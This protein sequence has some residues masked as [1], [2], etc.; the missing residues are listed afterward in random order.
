MGHMVQVMGV[1]QQH[2]RRDPSELSRRISLV[3][4][5][6]TVTEL[7]ASGHGMRTSLPQYTITTHDGDQQAVVLYSKRSALLQR[8]YFHCDFCAHFPGHN[9][10]NAKNGAIATDKLYVLL[11]SSVLVDDLGAR[12]RLTGVSGAPE[13]ISGSGRVRANRDCRI[14]NIHRSRRF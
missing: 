9:Q 7:P 14:I 10:G 4:V 3:E 6:L 1:V 12:W 11:A 2:S 13:E 5:E 8:D